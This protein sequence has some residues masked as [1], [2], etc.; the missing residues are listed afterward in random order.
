LYTADIYQLYTIP[1]GEQQAE[2]PKIIY[3]AAENVLGHDGAES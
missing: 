1:F 2:L 3:M